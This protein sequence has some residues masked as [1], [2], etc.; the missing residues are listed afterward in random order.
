MR[1]ART[2][3]FSAIILVLTLFGFSLET[4][5]DDYAGLVKVFQSPPAEDRSAPLWVWNDRM[6]KDE[7]STQLRDFCDR[8]IGGVFI[9][10]RPGL[11]T[12]YLSEEWLGLCAYA[13]EVG[14]GLGM[15]VWIY[16]ENSYPSGFAGGHVPAQMPDA[17]RAG[18]RMKRVDRIPETLDPSPLL[19]LRRAKDGFL[20]VSVA[21][22][23]RLG[24]GDY[25]LFDVIHAAPSPWH[26]GFTYVDIMRRDVT[27]KFLDITLEAYKKAFGAEF[28]RV[29]PGVFQDEAEIGPA[30]DADTVNYTPALFD[31]FQARWGYDLRDR[32]PSL[33]LEEGN[34]RC[35]RH[36]YYA[37]LL[38]LFI[39]NWAVPYYDY[40]ARNNLVFT[41]HYWE[42][43]WPRPR[44]S[45]DSMAMAAHAHM[46]GI[47]I[48]MN[49]YETGPHAQFGNARSVR[50]IRSS[51]NQL[52]RRR[53]LSETYGASGWDLS[54]L[55]Q[56]RIADWEYALGVN[57]LCQ[58]LSYV[59]IKGARKRDHPQSFSYHE[60][61][62]PAYRL[63]ADYFGRLSAVMSAGRQVNRVLVIEPTTSAWM[64][65][66][67]A[68][69]SARFEEI[70]KA[71]QDFIN[72][73]EAEQ[74][75][76][77]L[78]SEA[79]IKE[80]GR[81]EPEK[82]LIGQAAYDL[83]VLPPGISN[84]NTETDL[85][86]EELLTR[87]GKVLSFV[88]P[89][90]HVDGCPDT[91]LDEASVSFGG[92]WI[93]T[94]LEH[95]FD[96]LEK[97]GLQELTFLD[98]GR[99][100]GLLF[101]QHRKLADADL[102][103]L[104]NTSL[105]EQASGRFIGPG[106]FAERWD[107]FT[108]QIA[109]YPSQVSE[110]GQA[111]AF[112]VPPAGSL[113]LF[114][115][116]GRPGTAVASREFVL[117]NELAASRGLT[118]TAVSPNVLTLDYCDLLLAG[119]EDKDLYFYDAQTKVFN[120]HGF[121]RNPW[122]SSVQYKTE[123]ID[124]N[125]FGPGTGFEAVYWFDVAEGVPLGTL[126]AVAEQPA[127][128]TVSINGRTVTPLAG[129][130]WLD[131]AFGVYDIGAAVH[132]GRNSLSVKSSPFTIFSE[133]EP[134]YILGD[135]RLASRDKGFGLIPP[136]DL[137]LGSWKAQGLPFYAAGVRYEKAFSLPAID[138]KKERRVLKLGDWQ[139]ALAEAFVDGRSAGLIA[140]PPYELDLSERLAA[141]E[142]RIAVVVYGTLKNT[143]G[144]HHNNPARGMAWPS[145]FQ[146]GA[147]SGYPPGSAYDV[148]D[149]GLL[150]DFRLER[151]AQKE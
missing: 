42:H 143:L 88:Q 78:A 11:I 6:T 33:F 110:K 89:P 15:N 137:K 126:Q 112:D 35:V 146:K 46:P 98:K 74:V 44:T 4:P 49:Q 76:Y 72:K 80:L 60:P 29:V 14:K 18:L 106:S 7:I 118:V 69:S 52:G 68:G 142:H 32:L 24:M 58:H 90:V 124:K 8:G 43:E 97:M 56:K 12:P 86:I 1:H 91:A 28:G 135:F 109:S 139:G 26:G 41:G 122:D 101:H 39:Q 31:A 120:H 17:A 136:A 16:D 115:R 22:A 92:R 140:F 62:W 38:D 125:T 23:R 73:L 148:R 63:M 128:F 45:P 119:K 85:L 20:R 149:Y 75:E 27:L 100:P 134:V 111:V 133:L 99:N 123:I 116:T 53:T 104:C 150:E 48:L 129:R 70:G 51:A 59:T 37:T 30:G 82:F 81:V 87:G 50:E 5:R 102:V 25:F 108:G 95:G 54:F 121:A 40:C 36:N 138:V 127:L 2:L 34:W 47:D 113:L 83:I 103:F 13:V 151:R 21:E 131:R 65:Y 94:D 77:D 10:P 107:P 61:W 147:A 96:V 57:F 9:H 84:T 141:G 114:L 3:A 117:R 105:T 79:T 19:I 64:Y 132:P 55:D 67:P 145:M 130:W 144:P 93:Q 66:S 71:F